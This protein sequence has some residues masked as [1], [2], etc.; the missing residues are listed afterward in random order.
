MS[1]RGSRTRHTHIYITMVLFL[2]AIAILVPIF[3]MIL[4]S[5]TPKNESWL[6]LIPSHPTLSVYFT[7]LSNKRLLHY[8]VNTWIL[9]GSSVLLVLIM[10]SVGGYGLSRFRFRGQNIFIFLM[11]I[12]QGFAPITLS[13]SYFR[14]AKILNLYNTYSFLIL[15]YVA[16]CLPFSTF[17]MRAF[18]N[19]VPRE[20]E[21]AAMIDGC[22]RIV[23]LFRITLPL[24]YPGLIATGLYAFIQS[25][26][27]YLYPLLFTSDWTRAPITVYLSTL[28]G[29]YMTDWNQTM[30]VS[31]LTCLP[32]MILFSI[33]HN[34]FTR[35]V[36]G[37][38]K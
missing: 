8:F 5:I 9:T 6:S 15:I 10:A 19:A 29:Q 18:F 34:Q 36:T 38:L 28:K 27:Q 33:F 23:L 7:A 26:N 32:A 37:A 30:V 25:W 16:M 11:L 21:E 20:I 35:G 12:T 22:T 24:S 14:I 31:L 4:I 17:I 3:Y 1:L 13:I 2:C